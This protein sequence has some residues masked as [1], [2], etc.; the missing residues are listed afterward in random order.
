MP[1]PYRVGIFF[2]PKPSLQVLRTGF[3][4]YGIGTAAAD[5]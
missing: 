1:T 3:P 2:L 5:A 4:R